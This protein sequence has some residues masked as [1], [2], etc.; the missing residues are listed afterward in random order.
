M[1]KNEH[2]EENADRDIK[3]PDA[4]QSGDNIIDENTND[5]TSCKNCEEDQFYQ[6]RWKI[7]KWSCQET[8][9][10]QS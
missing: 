2:D 5:I 8:C 9:S 6:D 7:R 10:G 4:M 3:S 1:D